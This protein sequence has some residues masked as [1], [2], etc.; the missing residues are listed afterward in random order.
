MRIEAL[1]ADHGKDVQKCSKTS[2]VVWNGDGTSD[3]EV[4][5]EDGGG[6]VEDDEMVIRGDET[7]QNKE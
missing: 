5:G 1:S 4:G 2:D 6:R 3:R 7:G